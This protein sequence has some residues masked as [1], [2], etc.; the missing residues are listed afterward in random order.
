MP[1]KIYA[2]VGDTLQ[3]FYRGMIQSFNPYQYDIL[4][5]C[6]KGK[7][8]PRY[9]EFT[10]TADDIGEYKFTLYLKN[11]SGIIVSQGETTIKVVATKPAPDN[12]INIACFGDSLTSGG[13][14]CKEANRRLTE[15][16]GSPQ[17]L[18]LNNIAFVGSMQNGNTNYFGQ[19]GWRWSHYVSA[20]AP[21]FRFFVQNA[22]ALALDDI[23]EQNGHDYQIK[24]INIT[25]GTGN[26][27]CTT[28][29]NANPSASGALLKKSGNGDSQITYTSRE[30]DAR[31][32]LWD[33]T[34]NKMT[35]I[36]YANEVANGRIDMVYVLLGWNDVHRESYPYPNMM[37]DCKTFLN[38]LHSEFPAAKVKLMGLQVCSVNGGMG[39]NYGATGTAY[40]DTYGTIR[41]VMELNAAYKDLA[42]SSEY[43]GFV[44]YVDIA[45]Q[46]D[47]EYNMP[48]DDVPVNTRSSTTERRGS[49]GVHPSTDGYMQIADAVFRN[50]VANL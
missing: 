41:K 36:P 44:E 23:Y 31:N 40:A 42:K 15:S 4:V 19:G 43:S 49:N 9:F 16:G 33:T 13:V 20:G 35:F 2:V 32:P 47:S 24:E 14:W 34:Q 28:D 26:I 46:F 5:A 6:S 29:E 12:L 21:A 3:L 27:L 22:G 37:A 25:N 18:S 50:I 8:Y 11:D 48:A 45:S 1:P 30:S 7:Q 39:A 17:G 38:T 10:P